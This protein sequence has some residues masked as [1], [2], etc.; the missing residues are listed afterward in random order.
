VKVQNGVADALAAQPEQRAF[1]ERPPAERRSGL[2]DEAG[3]G[4]EPRSEAGR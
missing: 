1:G 3:E 2:G 4:V